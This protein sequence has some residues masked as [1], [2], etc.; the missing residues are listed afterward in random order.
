MFTLANQQGQDKGCDRPWCFGVFCG[1]VLTWANWGWHVSGMAPGCSHSIPT[2][3]AGYVHELGGSPVQRD[4][5]KINQ[6]S[7]ISS[8]FEAH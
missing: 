7:L 6:S 8:L 1:V 2:T 5:P 4:S 3:Q